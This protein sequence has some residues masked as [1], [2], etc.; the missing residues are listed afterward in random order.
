MEGGLN[1]YT[2]ALSNP[3]RNYDPTGEVAFALPIVAGCLDAAS[4]WATRFGIGLLMSSLLES[5][6]DKGEKAAERRA[7]KKRCT[8]PPPPGLSGCDLLRW[9][10]QRNMDCKRMREEF[11]KKWYGDG[12]PNHAA[13]IANLDTAIRKLEQAIAEQCNCCKK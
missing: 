5:D 4:V 2:Y 3:T 10:L 9:L 11:G 7:Y 8:E 13:E 1:T 6:A 12:D